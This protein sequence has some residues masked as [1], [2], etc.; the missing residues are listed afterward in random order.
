MNFLKSITQIITT[1]KLS[2]IE[3]LDK[4]LISNKDSI[5]TKY[6]DGIINNQI[7]NDQD[8]VIYLYGDND[9]A[10]LKNYR[11]LKS[12]FKKRLLNTLFFIDVNSKDYETE[13]QK[14]YFDCLRSL[15]Q[16]NIIQKYGG[17]QSLV[18]DIIQDNYLIAKKYEFID[19]LKEYSYKLV[20]YYSLK[21]NVQKFTEYNELFVQYKSIQSNIEDTYMLFSSINCYLGATK[22]TSDEMIEQFLVEIDKMEKLCISYLAKCYVYLS[23]LLLFEYQ[24]DFQKIGEISDEFLIHLDIQDNAFRQSFRGIAN[25]YKISTLLQLREYEKGITYIEENTHNL[26]GIN[27]FEAM[28][29]KLKFALNLNN[30]EL[31][32]NILNEVYSHKSFD[33]LPSNIKEK[34]YINESYIIFYDSYIN[35]GNY[36]FNLGKF[37]NQL[38]HYYHD[39]SGYNLSIIIVQILFQLARNNR[40][41][42]LQLI[43]SLRIYKTRYLK[44]E[45]QV[46]SSEFLKALFYFEKN[47]L[48]KKRFESALTTFSNNIPKSAHIF[49]HEIIAY[50]TLLSIIQ[51]LM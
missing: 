13:V 18:H 7:V 26:F 8:A 5:L 9:D 22:K 37:I 3:M 31:S 27:W 50:E 2:K 43:N 33:N 36:K 44:D 34:W 39:K 25:Y 1:R 49:D 41:E 24:H 42:V 47:F 16:I 15:Q 6:Y 32:N 46:R 11:Q 21:G 35:N 40:D 45:E 30:I 14:S 19:I 4:N 38:P 17:N 12:R 20:T 48:N 29:I 23:K 28:D 51:K 10:S